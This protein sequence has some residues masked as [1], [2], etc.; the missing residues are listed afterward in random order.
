MRVL[1][2]GTPSVAAD[3]LRGLLDD[4]RHEVI[5]VLTRPD[6][7]K[8]RSGRPVPSPVAVLAHERGLTV[9]RPAK[10]GDADF[11]AQLAALAPDVCVV[12][13]YGGM[14]PSSM[15]DV[16]AFGWANVHYS[17]L[18][19]WRGAAPVQ[20]AILAGDETTGVSV[21]RL[22]AA[23]DAGPVLAQTPCPVGGRDSGELLDTLAGIGTAT[24][25]RCLD[26]LGTGVATP[27]EQSD[28]GMTLA[29]KLTPEDARIDWSRPADE[30]WRL[31]RACHP[32]PVAWTTLGGERF[33]ILG[34]Q[35]ADV[36]GLRA[37]VAGTPSLLPGAVWTTKRSVVVGCG[38]GALELTTVQPQGRRP[39][40]AADWGRGL[41]ADVEFV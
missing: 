29:P 2:A 31:V 35:V 4:G 21:I 15:L 27:A 9:Y 20:H 10:P 34:A 7:P 24:L 12:V 33:R 22:V 5:G 8:G 36:P 19:R 26:D 23:L 37:D 28:D 38:Q 41:R 18:P 11:R 1:F 40:A 6:A 25:L 17:L 39:M 16:P 14:I 3:T 30:V 32:A 13:A